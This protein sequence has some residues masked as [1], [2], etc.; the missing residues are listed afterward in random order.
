MKEEILFSI[1]LAEKLIDGAKTN[2]AFPNHNWNNWENCM[3]IKG[4]FEFEGR[5]Y[6]L[7]FIYIEEYDRVSAHIVYG[8]EEWEY[9]SGDSFWGSDGIYKEL[10]W[11]LYIL[12]ILDKQILIQH[13]VNNTDWTKFYTG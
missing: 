7:G 11:R 1:H 13:Y 3:P 2:L 6:D 9:L 10:A 5:L 4:S 8:N 12:G